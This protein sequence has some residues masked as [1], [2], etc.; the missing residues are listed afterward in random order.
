MKKRHAR[1]R[2]R[3]LNQ[4]VAELEDYQ[5]YFAKKNKGD[6]FVTP[7]ETACEL[8]SGP[9]FLIERNDQIMELLSMIPL[10]D[11]NT[12]KD[13]AMAELTDPIVPEEKTLAPPP[14][15]ASPSEDEMDTSE[16]EEDS[17]ND[18]PQDGGGVGGG[19]GKAGID[20]EAI[21]ERKMK[22]STIIKVS[23][24]GADIMRK[25]WSFA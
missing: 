3:L 7:T 2:E 13:T 17:L 23:A 24:D 22:Y 10:M 4:Q 20:D 19:G 14:P 6:I 1:Q 16:D 18:M 11:K 5:K 9:D 15:P 12:E 25:C 21:N 8:M